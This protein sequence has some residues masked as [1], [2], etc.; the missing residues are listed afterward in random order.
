MNFI[1]CYVYFVKNV[2]HDFQLLQMGQTVTLM[3]WKEALM[4]RKFYSTAF[5][6]GLVAK[7]YF[8]FFCNP[9]MCQLSYSALLRGLKTYGLKR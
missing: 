5:I 8:S 2:Y 1:F 9:D 6:V 7:Q 4:K 3:N